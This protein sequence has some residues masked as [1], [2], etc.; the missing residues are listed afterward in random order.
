MDGETFGHHRP[1]LEK[2]LSSLFELPM[3]TFLQITDVIN[4]FPVGE[5]VA[6]IASTWASSISDIEKNVQFISW[7]DPSNQLHLW[8]K[9]LF[10][11]AF[12]VFSRVDKSDACRFPEL[13]N[14]MDEAE[15]SDHFWWASAKPWWSMEMIEQGSFRLMQIVKTSGVASESEVSMASELYLKIVSTAFE[16]QRSGKIRQMAS[17]RDNNLKIPFKERTFEV[18]GEQGAIYQAFI[19]MMKNLEKKAVGR[20]EYEMAIFWRDAVEKIENKSDI[21]DVIHAVDVLRTKIPNEEVEKMLDKYTEVY[22]KIR[23]GQPEQR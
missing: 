9:E 15:A 13:R 21:Y 7:N 2:V 19:E 16:W 18:G 8:Q 5:S 6:P 3:I 4:R 22:R 14:K 20:E 23:G 17:E 1:G 12:N 10:D 11:L